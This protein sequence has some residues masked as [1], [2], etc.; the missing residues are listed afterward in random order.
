MFKFLIRVIIAL[1]LC[2]CLLAAVLMKP[3]FIGI[4]KVGLPAEIV[5]TAS[6]T[7]SS[8]GAD[9]EKQHLIDW[10]WGYMLYALID[11]NTQ[12]PEPGRYQLQPGS[13]YRNIARRLTLGP[14]RSESQLTIIE[15][16]T[17]DDIAEYLTSQQGVNAMQTRLLIGASANKAAFDEGLR[18]QYTFLKD[19][20][21]DRSLE[22]YLYPET[23]RV[24]SDELPQGL[25]RKQLAEFERRYA[26]AEPGPKSAPL[27][28]LDD[29]IILASIVEKE[30]PHP[31]DRKRVAGL[32]LNR[33][34][35]G[36]P[37]QT[38][39][40]LNYLTNSGR[41]RANA[42]DLSIDSA[43]NSYKYKGLPP[44]PIAN[45]GEAAI[46]AVLNPEEND[47]LFFLTDKQNNVLYGKT[48]EEH[49]KNRAKAGY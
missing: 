39:A 35:I 49:A 24:W 22:G 15:G 23:Y 21:K 11:S 7:P 44:S 45:P 29:V 26:S 20:P 32:F 13:A 5:V 19:L 37:L 31:Q 3:A 43:F 42:S 9:L 28:T 10:G 27:K 46:D 14:E 47:Y 48:A 12:K 34:R 36:M 30:V 1:V 8:I 18:D 41:A 6:S 33:L 25:I 17:V 2:V 38:D 16:W 40:T 4:Q